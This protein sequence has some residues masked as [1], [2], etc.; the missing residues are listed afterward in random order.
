[1]VTDKESHSMGLRLDSETYQE[2]ETLSKKFEV[3][4]SQIIK[5]AI[6]RFHASEMND[7]SSQQVLFDKTT[8]RRV[9]EFLEPAQIESLGIQN[10][11]NHI[12]KIRKRLMQKIQKS[13]SD[14]GLEIFLSKF[15]LILSKK[16][17]KWIESIKWQF[18]TTHEL[19]LFINHDINTNFSLFMKVLFKHILHQVFSSEIME[20]KSIMAENQLELHFK[21]SEKKDNK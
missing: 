8:F 6:H 12:I 2:I 1:M 10:A 17:L 9:F 11:Q 3:N 7:F 20:D 13:G 18:L 16:H 14:G 15:N 5:M 19:L 21:L 4:K